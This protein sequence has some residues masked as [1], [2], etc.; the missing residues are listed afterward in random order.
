MP[1]QSAQGLGLLEQGARRVV[2]RMATRGDWFDNVVDFKARQLAHLRRTGLPH[3]IVAGHS[4]TFD[5]CEPARLSRA[6]PGTPEAYNAGVNLAPLG[7]LR[8]WVRYVLAVAKPR[9]L[10]IGLTTVDLNRNG[11]EQKELFDRHS[12]SRMGLRQGLPDL[13]APEFEP[14]WARELARN[15]PRL[16]RAR[17]RG[18]PLGLAKAQYLIG[19]DG[20][21]FHKTAASYRC[22]AGFADRF[23]NKWLVDFSIGEEQVRAVQEMFQAGKESGA[24]IALFVPPFTEDYVAMHPS[25][26]R[27]VE[28]VMEAYESIAA[29]VGGQFLMAPRSAFSER[30]FA[31]PIHL[32]DVGMRKCTDWLASAL[33][34]GAES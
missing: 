25:G 19:P 27:N 5:A 9:R 24:E 10:V 28:D 32:N 17:K 23:R 22:S 14:T 2:P 20:R 33:M 8:D 15:L 18:Q 12:R 6:L 21:D 30:D 3:L 13:S 31:D 29:A 7:L 4:M 26:A 11:I 34:R 16:A 1:R